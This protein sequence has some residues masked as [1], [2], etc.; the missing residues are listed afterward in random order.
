VSAGGVSIHLFLHGH[1]GLPCTELN[2]EDQAE[3]YSGA[4]RSNWLVLAERG[5]LA[6][7]RGPMKV[8]SQKSEIRFILLSLLVSSFCFAAGCD[9][10]NPSLAPVSGKVFYQNQPLP[11]G[12]IVFVPD[13]DRG[14]NGP[15]AQGSIQA[16][17][18]YAIQTEGKPGAL[19]GWYRVTVISVENAS[20][21]SGSVS[22]VPRSLVPERYRD[23]QL[24]DLT[25]EVKAGQDNGINFNLTP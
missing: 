21:F 1:G 5:K 13:A 20:G 15:L 2:S 11:R 8:R 10:T 23:P 24:S 6:M 14:N 16:G 4:K 19:P 12:T 3:D 9:G 22:S 25:C 17:G 18:S 7:I